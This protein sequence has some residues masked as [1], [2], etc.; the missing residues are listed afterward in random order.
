[1]IQKFLGPMNSGMVMSIGYHDH[2][3]D[4]TF[5]DNFLLEYIKNHQ[6]FCWKSNLQYFSHSIQFVIKYLNRMNIRSALLLFSSQIQEFTIKRIIIMKN[7]HD[8]AF[9]KI[10]IWFL[11]LIKLFEINWMI[12]KSIISNY[13]LIP[14]DSTQLIRPS[15]D[16]LELSIIIR[17][18][19]Q[20]DVTV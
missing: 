16:Y 2:D 3:D 8:Y 14:I 15:V 5:L 1:M 13:N 4:K 19:L 12:G 18:I 9:S 17:A 11:W 7:W 10:V 6:N 20:Y